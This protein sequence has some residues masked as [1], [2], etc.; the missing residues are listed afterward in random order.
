MN[1]MR[2]ELEE[3]PTDVDKLEN[4]MTEKFMA[5]IRPD[6]T[7]DGFTFDSTK[8][9]TQFAAVEAAMGTY[10]YP[11][12]N[13]MVDDVDATIDQFKSALNAAG[14]QDILDEMGISSIE[15][16]EQFLE[17]G[18]YAK[19]KYGMYAFAGS[20]TDG[21]FEQYQP[22]FAAFGCG[23]V[24]PSE[25]GFV[26]KDGVVMESSRTENAKNALTF[27][28]TLYREDLI[29]KDYLSIG[30]SYRDMYT[31]TGKAFSWY[32]ACGVL[33]SIE[34]NLK[35]INESADISLAE[36][37]NKDQHVGR[38]GWNAM[39][40]LAFIPTTC[41][42]PVAALDFFEYVNS[43]AGRDLC[44]AGI[45]GVTMTEDGV[46]EDGLFTPIAEGCA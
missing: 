15:T 5:N 22:L 26:V 29:N 34:K 44:V 18:R 20:S 11:L 35:T 1:Y 25:R 40:T 3:N 14:M 39:W 30:D 16:S 45:P 19:E 28:N 2:D 6:V 32:A 24:H 17:V 8:V 36:P 7:L 12:L 4:E 13:G 23:S 27:L 46:A 10:W 31:A 9:S 33:P 42:D 37:M 43:R 41:T 21:N 38:L